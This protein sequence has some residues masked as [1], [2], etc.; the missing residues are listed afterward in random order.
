MP[1]ADVDE[2]HALD[3]VWPRNGCLQT[4]QPPDAVADDVARA[5]RNLGQEAA[6]L[7]GWSKYR[8]RTGQSGSRMVVQL[9]QRLSHHVTT[10]FPL[11][12][13]RCTAPL[14]LTCSPQRGKQ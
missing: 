14:C 13:K 8:A 11:K 6:Q 12:C 1:E 2:L 9:A 5:A 4:R 10:L 7:W 3:Q